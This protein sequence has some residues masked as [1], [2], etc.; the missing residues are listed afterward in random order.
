[1]ATSTAI[2]TF[3]RVRPC[4]Q[5]DTHFEPPDAENKSVEV[6]VPEDTAHGF[7]N[8]KRSHWKFSFGGVLDRDTSQEDVFERVAQNFAA[9]GYPDL[10]DLQG[11]LIERGNEAAEKYPKLDRILSAEILTT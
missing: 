2:T 8:N 3:L 6:H 1:M 4:K 9:N 10:G 5:R 11:E 7:V